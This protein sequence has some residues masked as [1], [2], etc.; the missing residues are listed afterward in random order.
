LN[1]RYALAVRMRNE[2]NTVAQI[3]QALGV[4]RE[5]IH[6]MLRLVKQRQAEEARQDTEPFL[7]LSPRVR[8]HLLALFPS[9]EHP[10]PSELREMMRT[11]LLKKIPNLGKLSLRQIEAWLQS[12]GV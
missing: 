10:K 11:G 3:G 8:R 4:S 1:E 2:G 7:T 5:R 6:Q 9:G 12:Q